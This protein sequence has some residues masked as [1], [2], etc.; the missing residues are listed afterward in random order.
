MRDN[1]DINAG[2]IADGDAT[3]QEV[4]KEIFE[5]LLAIASGERTSSESASGNQPSS[6]RGVSALCCKKKAATD[7]IGLTQIRT[8]LALICVH[9]ILSVAKFFPGHLFT[10]LYQYCTYT[11]IT[12][13]DCGLPHPAGAARRPVSRLR[14]HEA[15]GA[16]IRRRGGVSEI[17]SLYRLLGRLLDDGL[18]AEG[19]N[20]GRRR[21][22]RLTPLGRR[23]LKEDAARL[24]GLVALV[25]DRGLLPETE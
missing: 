18:I 11:R 6:P 19:K 20:D 9:P 16:R 12:Y 24:A 15:R 4:G 22:Y 17:G 25:R 3:I 21:Y 5:K 13:A 23:T 1:M 10:S 14:H 8:E 2:R 7:K